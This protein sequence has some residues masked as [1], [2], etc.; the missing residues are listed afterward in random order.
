[1]K[2]KYI[3]LIL[4]TLFVIFLFSYVRFTLKQLLGA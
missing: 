3:F 1:M 2:L 4:V